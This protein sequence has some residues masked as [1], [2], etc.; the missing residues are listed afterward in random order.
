MHLIS[1]ITFLMTAFHCSGDGHSYFVY[2][3]DCIRECV[4]KSEACTINLNVEGNFDKI[5]YTESDACEGKA[6]PLEVCLQCNQLP[7]GGQLIWDLYKERYYPEPP[8]VRYIYNI[9]FIVF[10][11]VCG[12]ICGVLSHRYCSLRCFTRR[13][14]YE[15]IRPS[16]EVY[17]DTVEPLSED[18]DGAHV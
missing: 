3:S 7:K 8:L 6:T 11:F 9:Y 12:T 5:C 17:R 18:E 14:N 15:R 4:E 2:R 13:G 1:I 16:Q 10:I